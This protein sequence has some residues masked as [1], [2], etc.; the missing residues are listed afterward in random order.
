MKAG[1]SPNEFLT[2]DNIAAILAPIDKAV[3][4]IAAIF[5]GNGTAAAC[6]IALILSAAA[7]A[8]AAVT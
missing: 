5:P 4:E 3:N 1:I 2:V 8:L 7:T 6:E